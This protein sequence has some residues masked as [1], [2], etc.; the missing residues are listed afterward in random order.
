M[1]QY[2]WLPSEPTAQM[3]LVSGDAVWARHR[4]DIDDDVL[5]TIY[6]AMWQAAPKREPLIAELINALEVARTALCNE[7]IFIDEVGDVLHKAHGIASD[8]RL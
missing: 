3:V 6:R 5:S 2:K 4:L 8:S 7:G 1:T